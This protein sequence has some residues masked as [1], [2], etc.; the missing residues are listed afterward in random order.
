[1]SLDYLN[2]NSWEYNVENWVYVVLSRVRTRTGLGLN[3][4]LDMKKKFKV[5]EKLLSFE[6]R[7]K[8]RE[9]QYLKEVHG[10]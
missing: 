1:M 2:V 8:K 10:L 7:M 3:R 6:A 5:P 9:E 4:M